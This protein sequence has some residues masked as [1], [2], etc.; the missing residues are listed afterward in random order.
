MMEALSVYILVII[1]YSIAFTFADDDDTCSREDLLFNR[2]PNTKIDVPYQFILH[3]I[4]VSQP[5]MCFGTCQYQP[6]CRSFNAIKIE[7]N[8][9]ECQFLKLN[10]YHIPKKRVL[11]SP[12]STYFEINQM[13]SLN[14]EPFK[15]CTEINE[16]GMQED[17]EY[18]IFVKGKHHQVLCSLQKEF[19]YTVIQKRRNSA[20]G[21]NRSWTDFKKGFGNFENGF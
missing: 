12:T 4:T 3:N 17:G 13:C 20:E 14:V 10:Q 15:D 7:Q 5:E 6:S 11:R 1:T 21:F 2:I 9:F 8:K 16:H 19:G 18:T